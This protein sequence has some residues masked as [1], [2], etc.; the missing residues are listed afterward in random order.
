MAKRRLFFLILAGCV[1]LNACAS[2][3]NPAKRGKKNLGTAVTAPLKDFGI[4]R[5][6]A[7]KQLSQ[8]GYPYD[9]ARLDNGCAQVGYEIGALDTLLGAESYLPP[10]PKGMVKEAANTTGQVVAGAAEGV[11]TGAIP[12]RGVV[13]GVSGAA[14]AD[15]KVDNAIFMGQL[16]RAF[17]RGYGAASGCQGVLAP[18]A[19]P[20][21]PPPPPVQGV[22][23]PP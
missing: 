6:E 20:P 15:A 11:T 23:A 12:F 8:I 7:P 2:T 21:P 19:P 10:P 13:R 14:A 5:P 18:G 16:R 17:L 9:P 22:G 1:G 3:V 4:V